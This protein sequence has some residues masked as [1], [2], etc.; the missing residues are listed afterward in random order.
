MFRKNPLMETLESRRCVMKTIRR[1][2]PRGTAVAALVG[3][4]VLGLAACGSSSSSG[5]GVGSTDSAASTSVAPSTTANGPTGATV[6]TAINSKLGT[7]L[8]DSAGRTLYT[9]TNNG[10]AV[11]CTGG[12][13]TAWPPLLLAG[14]E[15]SV[16]GGKGVTGLATTSAAGG[17]Q[18]TENGLPL[19]HFS[20]DTNAGDANGEGITSF[21]GTWHAAKAGGSDTQTSSGGAGATPTTS[22]GPTTSS[23]YPY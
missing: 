7:I 12:C 5:T 2:R 11:A 18:V 21:G 1:V 13:L 19:F 3:V 9:L 17:T 23:A 20:G 10:T 4:A 15:T 22:P 16:M 14:G 6:S 8:V